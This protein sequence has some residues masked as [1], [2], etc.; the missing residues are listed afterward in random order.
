VAAIAD[1]EATLTFTTE[2]KKIIE[3]SDIPPDLVFN[4]VERGLCWKYVVTV[5]NLHLEGW[6]IGA[7]LQGI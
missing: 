3:D 7:W 6:K 1:I 4:V 5:K 2:F